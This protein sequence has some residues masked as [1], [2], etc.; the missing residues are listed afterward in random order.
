MIM[1]KPALPQF[2][3]SVAAKRLLLVYILLSVVAYAI[4]LVNTP[5][6]VLATAGHDDAL[7]MRL[8]QHLADGQWL[9]R[10]DQF[11]LMKGPGY[12]AFLALSSWLGIPVSLSHALFH[13][14]VV[15]FF[16]A[17]CN[18]FV[19]SCL[20][21]AILFSLLL[22]HPISYTSSLL[23]VIRE[24]IYCDQILLLL[25]AMTYALFCTTSN[26][27]R[28]LWGALAGALL[29]W[30]WLTREE[31]IWL[32]PALAI[33]LAA[34]VLRAVREGSMADIAAPVTA[35]FFVFTGTQ[36]AFRAVN[37]AVYG[38]FVGVDF[39]EANF[40]KA[41]GKL[42]SVVSGE[43]RP[44]VSVSVATREHIY[45]VSP[46]FASLR[47]Y[48]EGPNGDG[49][50]SGS[51]RQH[52]ATCGEIGAGWFMWVL[53]DAAANTGHY[54]SPASASAFFGQLAAEVSIACR[55]GALECKPG[56]IAEMP[57]VTL[58]QIAKIP[59][60]YLRAIELLVFPQLGLLAQPSTGD[61]EHL[62]SYLRLLND[63]LHT[64]SEDVVRP[65]T[66]TGWYY[67]SGQDWFSVQLTDAK[68]QGMSLERVQSSDIALH[69]KDP[70]AIQQRYILH[71]YCKVD[72][73]LQFSIP[74]GMKLEKKLSELK[75]PPIGFPLGSGTLY[76]I[77]LPTALRRLR[78]N[79]FSRSVRGIG[80][81][82]YSTIFLPFFVLG[83]FAFAAT[84]VLRLKAALSNVSYI[85]ALSAW[86]LV[87]MRATV[88]ILIEATSFP[89]LKDIYLSSAYLPLVSGAVLSIAAGLQ[90]FHG[91]ESI[92]TSALETRSAPLQLEERQPA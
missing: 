38:M 73:S 83:L 61:E 34:A 84:T 39:K 52:S 57:V 2:L 50:M 7:F 3:R 16:V 65:F 64:E 56:W 89:A 9:G 26:K 80:Q 76:I 53:R 92:P 86:M 68:G 75:H 20:L 58:D 77:R 69:F 13:C 48:F 14:G 40:Q 74:D 90:L 55:S 45:A 6:A 54:L 41:L 29:G 60:L 27:D 17:V 82:Y 88:V 78:R 25:G 15:V 85:L 59:S 44:F 18:R 30:I 67:R 49:W 51:C 8:G 66:I 43:V 32:I 87:L 1:D 33:L 10:Y 62:R 28:L 70:K 23:R 36:V 71:V 31:G 37:W 81:D 91:R 22:W 46:A 12:P 47:G 79:L 21:T 35:I 4:V 11:T 63:P 19:K 5:I 42:D 72:C 24:P